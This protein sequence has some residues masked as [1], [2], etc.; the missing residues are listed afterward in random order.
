MQGRNGGGTLSEISSGSPAGKREKVL[1]AACGEGYGSSLLAE[2]AEEVTGLDIDKE[3]VENANHKYGNKKL[4]YL[5]GSIEELPFEDHT[6][7]VVVSFETIE[8]VG[9]EIQ[10]NSWKKYAAC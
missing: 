4:S 3:A 5:K 8:H 6:L 9:E 2:E 1:D 7:D 10:K